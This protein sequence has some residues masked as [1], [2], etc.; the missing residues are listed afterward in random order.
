MRGRASVH[1]SGRLCCSVCFETNDQMGALAGMIVGA[2]TVIIWANAG[3]SDFLYEIIPGFA[4]SL[5]TVF[6]V[7][8]LTQ[9]PSQA[10]EDQFKDY[11]D[12]MSQ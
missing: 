1:H 12:T 7:S 9:A 5:L 2:A 10:V 3:L 6:I 11:Q 4:A 8:V